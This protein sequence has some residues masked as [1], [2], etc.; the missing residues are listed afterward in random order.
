MITPNQ[1]KR[2]VVTAQSDAQSRRHDLDALRAIAMLLGI[3]LHGAASFI[4]DT[5]WLVQDRQSGE[6]FALFLIAV[7]GFRMPVFFLLSGFFTA[8]LWRRRGLRALLQHRFRRVFLPLLLGMII[9]WPSLIGVGILGELTTTPNN[10]GKA[11]QAGDISE[12]VRLMNAGADVNAMIWEQT[13]LHIATAAGQREAAAW[14]IDHGADVN[15]PDHEGCTPLDTALARSR[16]NIADLLR[17]YGGTAGNAPKSSILSGLMDGELFAH[18]WFLWFLCW[19]VAGFAVCVVLVERLHVK[20]PPARWVSSSARYLW[21]VPLTMLP[22][23]FMQASSF[24]PDTSTGFLPMPHVLAY[25]ALFFGF[26]TLYYHDPKAAERDTRRWRLTLAT[27]LLV[28]FPLGLAFTFGDTQKHDGWT[29]PAVFFQSFYPW[30]MSF[31]LM[32][33]FYRFFSHESPLLRYISDSSYFLYLAHLPLI[34]A[35]QS[36]VQNWRWPAFVKFVLLCV[37][38]TGLLLFIYEHGVRYRWLGRFLNGPRPA[39][40]IKKP[41]VH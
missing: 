40:L 25:Y 18:L 8:M 4:P 26:G 31:G 24:G 9:V 32:G 12:L 21:L 27:G 35:V 29:L 30:L 15:A 41:H 13:P 22:Q 19:L 3:A 10:M 34:I 7:H 6:A 2:Q 33:F 1:E 16:H 39:Q 11:A 5:S 28:V 14:L 20:K 17:E 23:A 37:V 38:V 36:I